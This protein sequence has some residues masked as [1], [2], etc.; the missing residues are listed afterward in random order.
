[1]AKVKNSSF[2]DDILEAEELAEE[3]AKAKVK[4]EDIIEEITCD[5][6]DDLVQAIG[7]KDI[8]IACCDTKLYIRGVYNAKTV[9]NNKILLSF[10]FET[11]QRIR[12]ERE[13]NKT[14][15]TEE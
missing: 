2:Y 6:E 12:N 9:V 8:E 11:I 7:I 1:M 3:E 5:C 15:N 14:N 4:A 13:L 10:S